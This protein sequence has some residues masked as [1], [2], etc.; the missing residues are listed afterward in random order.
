MSNE[1]RVRVTRAA[2]LQG[3]RIEAGSTIKVQP[4]DAHALIANGKGE[5]LDQADEAA[6]LSAIATAARR[7]A[8]SGTSN[9]APRAWGLT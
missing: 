7:V 3:A 1:I 6:L 9:I 5:L 2:C 4:I 8:G